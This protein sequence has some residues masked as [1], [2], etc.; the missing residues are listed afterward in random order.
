MSLGLMVGR[1]VCHNLIE[2]WE[3]TLPCSFRSTCCILLTPNPY[4]PCVAPGSMLSQ[5]GAR[6]FAQFAVDAR[7]ANSWNK[8]VNRTPATTNKSKTH[9]LLLLQPQVFLKGLS[10]FIT[11]QIVD[12]FK[13]AAAVEFVQ[14]KITFF[15]KFPLSMRASL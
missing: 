10:C 5:L 12:F 7:T 8:K 13:A 9:F 14:V 6:H 1:S 3:V 2:G 15:A 11:L 4:L